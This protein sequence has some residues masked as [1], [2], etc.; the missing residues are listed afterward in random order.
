MGSFLGTFLT[1]L[2]AV[3]QI[4]LV[5]VAAA[6]LVKC[7]VLKSEHV[8]GLSVALVNVFLPC[9][10]F[11]NILSN[12]RPHETPLWWLMP[13][14]AAATVAIGLSIGAL[15]FAGRLRE[16]L[17][18]LAATAFQNAAYLMLPIGKVL[19]PDQFEQFALY[20]FL[21]ILVFNP[22][23]WSIGKTLITRGP[24]APAFRWRGLITPPLLANLIALSLVLTGLREGV[25]EMVLSATSLLGSAT[26]P[27]GTFVLGATIGSIPLRWTSHFGDIW[28]VA[29]G[30]LVLTPAV[31]ASI[32]A[33]SPLP[34]MYPLAALVIMLESASA[35]ATT[36]II[37]IQ[38]YG[39]DLAKTSMILVATY[40]ACL[41]T[42]P[43]WLSV[44]EWLV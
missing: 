10:I 29:L 24:G 26:V 30:K 5:T 32:L 4:A 21:Y 18:M 44:W 43:L 8:Q 3:A 9:L 17:G 15:L 6:L 31:V 22:L 2:G 7:R 23:L 19:F 34:N 38:A 35:P 41:I 39:G 20:I 13:L 16:K 12:L 28:R 27:V 42:I 37:Q 36:L 11:S 33:L 14:A 25:P 40:S 1:A